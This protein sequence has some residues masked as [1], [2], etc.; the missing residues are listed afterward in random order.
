MLPTLLIDGDIVAFRCASSAEGDNE[1]IAKARMEEMLVGIFDDLHSD[2]YRI[3]LTGENNFRYKLYPEYKANRIGR[4]KPRFLEDCKEHLIK[5]WNAE[6]TDGWEADDALGIAQTEAIAAESPS[7]IC[8]IDKDLKQIPGLHWNFV[9]KEEE[10]ISEFEGMRRF[11]TQVLT[12]DSTDNVPGLPG[13]G[14]VKAKGTLSGVGSINGLFDKT[15]AAYADD[16]YLRLMGRLLWVL[17]EPGK[18]WEFPYENKQCESEG[19]ET[20]P[21]GEGHSDWI[22]T[23]PE[24]R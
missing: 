17:R 15:R 22:S 23:A 14:P 16:S 1:R 8:S 6:L 21:M 5:Y 18:Q 3:Y 10:N 13:I 12:G 2:H 9:K 19:Q 11:Y 4:P 24:G 7:I 20:S